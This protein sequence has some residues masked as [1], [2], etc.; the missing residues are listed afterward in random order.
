MLELYNN[1]WLTFVD[2][3]LSKSKEPAQF[4]CC[5]IAIRAYL[6]GRERGILNLEVM[7]IPILFDATCSGM[8][9]LSALTSNMELASYVNIVSSVLYNKPADFYS[10]CAEAIMKE[11][12]D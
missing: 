6:A 2:D 12:K 3:Y 10:I 4:M 8:Q 9:H 7:R 5:L 1:D 11:I